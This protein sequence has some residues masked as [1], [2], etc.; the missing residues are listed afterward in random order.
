MVLK[1]IFEGKIQEMMRTR[2]RKSKNCWRVA[3]KLLFVHQKG[4]ENSRFWGPNNRF[5]WLEFISKE[6]IKEEEIEELQQLIEVLSSVQFVP[7]GADRR[8]WGPEK[9]KC[10]SVASFFKILTKEDNCQPLKS[11]GTYRDWCALCRC[12]PANFGSWG[13]STIKQGI[14]LLKMHRLNLETLLAQHGALHAWGRQTRENT[15]G[16]LIWH[17]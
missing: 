12:V 10:L 16:V 17:D 5:Y 4:R 15:K 9:N 8:V 7:H 1:R 2:S 6:G 14:F 11:S 3:Q 13:E